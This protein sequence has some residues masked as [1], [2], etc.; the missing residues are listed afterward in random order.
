MA[1][2]LGF[3][4][5][6]KAGVGVPKNGPRKPRFIQFWEIV[7]RKLGKLIQLNLLY[8]LMCLPIVTIGPATAGLT[9]VLRN[10]SQERHAYVIHDFFRIF[11][12]NF[13]QAF[14]MGIIDILFVVI[15]GFSIYFYGAYSQENKIF[16]IPYYLCLCATV[17][18]IFMH[19]Y[20]YIMIVTLD[21]NLKQI[22]KNAFYLTC[23]GIKTNLLTLLGVA[24]VFVPFYIAIMDLQ[25]IY[26]PFVLIALVLIPFALIGLIIC[27]NSYQY[28]R[29]YIIDPYY[30]ERGEPN[31][32][33][34]L[35]QS[36]NEGTVF[37]DMGGKEKPIKTK[38][39]VK[40]RKI[41]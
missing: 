32:E 20:I 22:L 5:Y 38:Q 9:Y 24:A 17:V 1:G 28:I 13:K 29:K 39:K 14:I 10:F 15:M 3:F 16:L 18:F 26:L 34:S 25:I 35:L 40:G 37:N 7:W 33:D 6:E 41:T 11:K 23:L 31:P 4:D 36:S 8:V 19:F 21:L 27:F 2:F 30:K 12:K